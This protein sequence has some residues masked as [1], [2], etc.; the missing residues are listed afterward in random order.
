[1]DGTPASQV[2]LTV[3]HE[4]V[5]AL[6][7]QYVN[8]DSLQKIRGDDD[9]EMAAQ[10]VIEGQA[11]FGQMR[12]MV[13]GDN[14]AFDMPSGWSRIRDEIR[15][16]HDAMPVFAAAPTIVQETLD[17]PV[18]V[19]RGVRAYLRADVAGKAAVHRHAGVD[20]A[21]HA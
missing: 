19:R 10:A 3:S 9:R 6:Q 7:D 13:G 21:D 14:V 4:L 15:N 2:E 11:V 18:S 5:H 1:M 20:R 12:S 8:L 16:N 17:F